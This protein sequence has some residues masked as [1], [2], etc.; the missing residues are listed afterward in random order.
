[1]Y[2]KLVLATGIVISWDLALDA[3]GLCG[4]T[5]IGGRPWMAIGQEV[6]E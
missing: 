4:L 3:W 2:I 5:N 6:D 1:M